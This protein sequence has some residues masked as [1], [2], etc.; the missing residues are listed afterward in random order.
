MLITQFNKG[1]GVIFLY[2]TLGFGESP[3]IFNQIQIVDM[4]CLQPVMLLGQNG[5]NL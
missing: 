1:I 3:Q 5:L 2:A 4:L